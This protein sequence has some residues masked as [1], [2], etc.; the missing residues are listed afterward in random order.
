[1]L[2]A[3][4]NHP[5]SEAEDDFRAKQIAVISCPD[6][7][8]DMFEVFLRDNGLPVSLAP[9][10][11]EELDRHF[12][13][14]DGFAISRVVAALRHPALLM[15]HDRDDDIVPFDRAER[16]AAAARAAIGDANVR[17][18]ATDNLGHG[19]I[20]RSREVARHLL[21]HLSQA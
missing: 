13:S 18:V 14:H 2:L 16:I 21:A 19:G 7:L 15:F 5:A 8:G 10:M 17:L 11:Q 12:P 4:T 9:V 6:N 3:A 20:L 1:L